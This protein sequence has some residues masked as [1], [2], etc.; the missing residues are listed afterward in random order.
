MLWRVDE[1]GRWTIDH[2]LT[3]QE[4]ATK[5]VDNQGTESAREL[6]VVNWL[7]F[8]KKYDRTSGLE[9]GDS[10]E[11][12]DVLDEDEDDHERIIHRRFGQL[13]ATKLLG[14][15]SPQ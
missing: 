3:V 8:C 9:S 14:Q 11:L 13:Y 4:Y 12:R 7:E 6:R 15:N 5:F 10:Q 1:C 2:T